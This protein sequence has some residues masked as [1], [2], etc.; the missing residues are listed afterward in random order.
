MSV[1]AIRK[2]WREAGLL[3][4]KR[5]K[6]KTKQDLREVKQKWA[7]F[8]QSCVDVKELKDIPELW[9]GIQRGMIPKYQYT[10]REVVSGLM[11]LAYADEYGMVHSCL[12][13]EV[14]LE[15]LKRCGFD[16]QGLS[17]QTDNGSEFIG[18]WN[19]RGDS[20][21]TKK[22]ESFKM[23]HKTIP[24]G[25]HTWQSDVETVHRLIEDEFY[26]SEKFNS[27]KDFREKAAAYQFFF[28]SYRKN[29]SKGSRSPWE[30]LC[31]RSNE[32]KISVLNL[33]P[34]RLDHMFE[35][36]PM[37]SGGCELIYDP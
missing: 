4:K 13:V 3:K 25:A 30:I 6:H 22:I 16:L 26:E 10:F 21:F 2:A 11:F 37:A 32:A 28:N 12:F 36:L 23:I 5:R 14:I 7:L 35:Q 15:H 17:I 33:K 24:A 20:E 1:I 34:F 18:A 29:R 27:A 9:P 8:E 31:E 19:K